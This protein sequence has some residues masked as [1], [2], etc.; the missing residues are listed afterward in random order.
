MNTAGAPPVAL[1][2]VLGPLVGIMAGFTINGLFAFGEEY[3][4]RGVLM[5]ELR[6]LGAFKANLLTGVMWG[7]WHAPVILLGFNYGAE[8]R[9]GHPDDV[10]RD[11]AAQLH[12][13]ARA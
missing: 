8:R 6:P 11:D 4:W 12:P 3:G 1:L 7:F 2:Y 10:R 9:L 5:D 13:L